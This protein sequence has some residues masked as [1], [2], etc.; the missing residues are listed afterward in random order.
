M[1]PDPVLQGVQDPPQSTP[2]SVP[3]FTPSHGQHHRMPHHGARSQPA[4]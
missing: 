1:V 4:L 2:V 3:F